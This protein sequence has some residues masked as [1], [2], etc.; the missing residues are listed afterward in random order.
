MKVLMVNTPQSPRFGGGDVTQMKQ[1]ASKLRML[2]V[3]V[4]LSFDLRP[5]PRGFDLAHVFNLRTIETTLQQVGHLHAWDVPIA[6]S[7]IYLDVSVPLWGGAAV[8]SIF[9]GEPSRAQLS[10]RLERLRCRRLAVKWRD[11]SEWHAD[12]RNRPYL[13]YD[14][15]QRRILSYCGHLLPNSVLELQA[16][17]RT[18][19]I[20]PSSF[21]VVPYGVDPDTFLD[22]D[23]QPFVNKYGLHDFILQVG[24]IERSKN[25]LLLA[26]ALREM[27]WPL[28]FIGKCDQS[29]YLA[30]CRRYGPQHLVVIPHL[31][32]AELRAAYAAARVHALPSWVETCGLVT[33]EAALAD[34]SVVV[35]TAGYEF[36][37]FR[38]LAY[39]CDSADYV[40][41]RN[42]VV[43][44][45][46]S[47][48]QDIDRRRQLREL[49]LKEYTW[50]RAAE[51]T[52][53]GYEKLLSRTDEPPHSSETYDGIAS[54]LESNMSIAAS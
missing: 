29:E 2:G 37:Y 5:D 34:C 9:R 50:E 35:S 18:L 39:Y 21:T 30:L 54:R 26:Y 52:L 25:Q 15:R 3:E 4:V 53:R 12:S 33:M 10:A 47:R 1:T 36:E 20:T 28:V 14:V 13:K 6:I 24:R 32:P 16:L 49:I 41:I 19:G 23:P 43:Q 42:A 11:Q 31:P 27:D 17:S 48:K 40:S 46:F 38:D 8:E 51:R 22:P 45:V 7:P 44:A